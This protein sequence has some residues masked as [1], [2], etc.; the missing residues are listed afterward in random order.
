MSGDD[1]EEIERKTQALEQ[2]STALLQKMYEQS[3]AA[4]RA[5]MAPPRGLESKKDDCADAS[6]KRS[7]KAI[8]RRPRA[9][10]SGRRPHLKSMV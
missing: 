10:R 3:A 5:P 4:A 2:A 6:S 1:R 7:R 8:V 9:S